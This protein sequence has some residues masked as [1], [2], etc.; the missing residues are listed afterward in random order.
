[1]IDTNAVAKSTHDAQLKMPYYLAYND[2]S[3][4]VVKHG[5]VRRLSAKGEPNSVVMLEQQGHVP[6]QKRYYGEDGLATKDIDY[7]NHG[8]PGVHPVVPHAHD[9]ENGRRKRGWRP[10]DDSEH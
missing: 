9:W 4:E 10:L 2:V 5:N 1:V 6:L 8:N 7:N 3:K